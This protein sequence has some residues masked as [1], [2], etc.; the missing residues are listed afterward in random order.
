MQELG[1]WGPEVCFNEASSGPCTVKLE[2]HQSIVTNHL[3]TDAVR[4]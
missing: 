2:N 3:G 1:V 4:K